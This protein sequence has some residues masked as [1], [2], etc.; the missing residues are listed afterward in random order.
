MFY[1]PAFLPNKDL[2]IGETYKVVKYLMLWT[3]RQGNISVKSTVYL[4]EGINRFFIY[5]CFKEVE[6]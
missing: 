4:L 6:P 2:V 1:A 3:Q 5:S